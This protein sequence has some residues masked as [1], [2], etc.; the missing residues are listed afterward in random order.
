MKVKLV[1]RVGSALHEEGALTLTIVSGELIALE[2][3]VWPR[4]ATEK[5]FA[6]LLQAGV[7]RTQRLCRR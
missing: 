5:T 4:G 6:N 3:R 7:V 2:G 1:P